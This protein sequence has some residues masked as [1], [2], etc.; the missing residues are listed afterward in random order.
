MTLLTNS[1]FPAT[2]GPLF[3][4]TLVADHQQEVSLRSSGKTIGSAGAEWFG[5]G[6]TINSGAPDGVSVNDYYPV[7]AASASFM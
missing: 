4:T 1:G 6:P 2:A 3:T 7:H 5:V